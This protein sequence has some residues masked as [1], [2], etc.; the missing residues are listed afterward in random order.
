[1]PLVPYVPDPTRYEDVF[2]IQTGHGPFIRYR[3]SLQNGSGFFPQILKNLFA[4]IANFARPILEPHARAAFEAAKPHLKEAA[5]GLVKE[6]T[7]RVSETIGKRLAPQQHGR[8][9]KRRSA[10]KRASKKPRYI[11]PKNMP[12]F[13]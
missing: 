5:S 1:M 3:G 8:G 13:I 9:R 4:K 7:D 2:V 10:I 12:D 6:A 11:P